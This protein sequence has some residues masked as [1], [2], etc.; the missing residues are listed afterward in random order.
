MVRAILAP[1]CRLHTPVRAFVMERWMIAT[2]G[3]GRS[4]RKF[5]A[6]RSVSRH[7]PWSQILSSN[8]IWVLIELRF[9]GQVDMTGLKG[10]S[11]SSHRQRFRASMP[12]NSPSAIRLCA[13]ASYQTGST[14]SGWEALRDMSRRTTAAR[15]AM[16]VSSRTDAQAVGRFQQPRAPFFFFPPHPPKKFFFFSFRMIPYNI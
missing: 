15:S 1:H 10:A 16:M 3:R 12:L 11:Q 6:A 7:W 13:A 4:M 14:R 9:A 8:L 2:E 5:E